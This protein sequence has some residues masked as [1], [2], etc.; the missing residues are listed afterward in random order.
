LCSKSNPYFNT[1]LWFYIEY[2]NGL[3]FLKF[4]LWSECKH[5]SSGENSFNFIRI[6]LSYTSILERRKL[7]ILYFI[8]LVLVLKVS[9]NELVNSFYFPLSRTELI[10]WSIDQYFHCNKQGLASRYLTWSRLSCQVS[11]VQ[12]VRREHNLLKW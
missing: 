10:K 6:V 4:E 7:R 2:L 3:L 1:D 8:P 11:P 5:Y 9:T 12:Q